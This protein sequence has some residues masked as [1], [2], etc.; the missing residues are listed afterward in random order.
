VLSREIWEG[1]GMKAGLGA[2]E[3]FLALLAES[4]LSSSWRAELTVGQ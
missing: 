3:S 1:G 2:A 4:R